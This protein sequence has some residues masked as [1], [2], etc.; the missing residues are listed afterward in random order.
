MARYDFSFLVMEANR[1]DGCLNG[2][3]YNKNT[4]TFWIT[5]KNWPFL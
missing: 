3:A 1:P 5:G 2:I 4:K